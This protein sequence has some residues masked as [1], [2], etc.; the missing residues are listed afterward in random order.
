V[1]RSGKTNF[2]HCKGPARPAA[3]DEQNYRI[4]FGRLL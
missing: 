3:R 1:I 4:S 2:F